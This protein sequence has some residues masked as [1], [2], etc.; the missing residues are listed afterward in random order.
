MVFNAEQYPSINH[1]QRVKT[2]WVMQGIASI[3]FTIGFLS[4]Y[5]N[6]NLHGKP[7]FMSYHG[8]CGLASMILLCFV[9]CGGGFTYYAFR[10]RGYVRPVLP[11]IFHAFGGMMFLIIGNIT[12]VLGLYTHFF[13]KFGNERLIFIF[14]TIIVLSTILTLRHSIG[15]LKERIL[16]TFVRNSL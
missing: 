12:M 5:I 6:K 4:V 13:K 11:K 2:H 3:C 16:S 8:L 9:C 14:S 1:K 15:T 10:L 7:H